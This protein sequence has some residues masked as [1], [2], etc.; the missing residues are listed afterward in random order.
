MKKLIACC[1]VVAMFSSVLALGGCDNSNY[2]IAYENYLNAY[3]SVAGNGNAVGLKF[4]NETSAL[5][6]VG[7]NVYPCSVK[8]QDEDSFV[9]TNSSCLE[10][11][12]VEE[13]E[14]EPNI[15]YVDFWENNATVSFS[16]FIRARIY[17]I[18]INDCLEKFFDFYEYKMQ[19]K[20]Q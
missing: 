14:D 11:G 6:S 8:A 19:V 9:L 15:F 17:N 4:V 10:E 2:L 7:E 16:V 5:V 12:G 18:V 20:R 13:K 3:M 1:F